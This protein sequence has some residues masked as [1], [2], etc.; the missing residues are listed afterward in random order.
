MDAATNAI[1]GLAARGGAVRDQAALAL[2]AI[3]LR[4]PES[5]VAWID[6]SPE[7]VRTTV[8]DLLKEGFERLEEDYAE[9]QFYAAARASYW[10]GADGSATR[11]LA[12]TLIQR[13]E[14]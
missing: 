4:R 14:F 7:N 13:L 10:K 1:V 5:I 2:S 6:A 8:I 9:E 3:A 11:T 12:A